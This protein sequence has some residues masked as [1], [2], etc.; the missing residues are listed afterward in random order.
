[1]AQ[2]VPGGD[3]IRVRPDITQEDRVEGLPIGTRGGT[4]IHYTFPRDG[5]YDIQVRL[6]RDRNDQV[7]G[8]HEAHELEVLL[9]RERMQ[10][11]TVNPPRDADHEHVDTHL[12]LRLPVKAGPHDLG[13]TFLKNPS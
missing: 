13:I 11:F 7:E 10:S 1:S 9:D 12:K 8:L 6:S 4:L 2:R 3:T 5:T